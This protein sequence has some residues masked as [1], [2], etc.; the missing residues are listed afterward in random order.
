MSAV[1][2]LTEL[3]LSRWAFDGPVVAPLLWKA[4]DLPRPAST[5]FCVREPLLSNRK[6]KP[7]DI[8][9]LVCTPHQP[10]QAVAFE[11]KRVK[12]KPTAFDTL[13]VG[14]LAG[15]NDSVHQVR[16]LLEIGLSRCYLLIF[17]AAD[18]RERNE[19][20]FAGRGPT[21]ALI[22]FIDDAVRRVAIPQ[23]VGVVSIELTQPTNRNFESAG[24]AGIRVLRAA[25]AQ[26]QPP[27][28]T[29]R[30]AWSFSREK[31]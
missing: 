5:R 20:N 4:L 31:I 28:L 27:E 21:G 30:V 10:D 18:G 23:Q 29:K 13:K 12:I 25:C 26:P 19:F 3:E 1:T 24:G 15:L 16:G 6:Q 22:R 9:A 17:V 7:G 2:E 14:K 11:C 8:D